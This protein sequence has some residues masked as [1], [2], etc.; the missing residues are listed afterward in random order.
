ML[1]GCNAASWAII[2][3]GEAEARA[4]PALA[5]VRKPACRSEKDSG[6]LKVPPT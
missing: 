3:N 5:V 2:S 4:I 1:A 6:Y